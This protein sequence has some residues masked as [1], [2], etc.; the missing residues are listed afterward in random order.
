MSPTASDR[1]LAPWPVLLTCAWLFT[2]V[3]IA[4]L[5]YLIARAVIDKTD[6]RDL[7]AV[8]TALSPLLIGMARSLNRLPSLGANLPPT[9]PTAHDAQ[10]DAQASGAA[11]ERNE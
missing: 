10:V 8:L 5:I 6:P 11:G 7:P 3:V 2:V 1:V 4:A 9:D